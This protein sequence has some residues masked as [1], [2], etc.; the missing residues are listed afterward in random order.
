MTV[1][2]DHHRLRRKPMEPFFSRSGVSRIEPLLHDLILTLVGRLDEFR[3]TGKIV[4]LDHVFSAMA[5]DVVSAICI[6]NPQVSFL[7]DPEFNP[8]W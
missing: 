7:R 6:E 4:R 8:R 5:G 2:H 3:G 1:G